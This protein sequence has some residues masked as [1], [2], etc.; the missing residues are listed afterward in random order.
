MPELILH[1]KTGFLVNTINEAV[2]AVARLASI[3]RKDC[4]EWVMGNFSKE[5]MTEDYLEVY[6]R[7][8]N[9]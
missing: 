7:I 1:D 3:E 9:N 4:R 5:K 2:T 8:L 6:R